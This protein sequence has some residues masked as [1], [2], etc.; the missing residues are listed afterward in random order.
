M[1]NNLLPEFRNY[2]LSNNIVPQKKIQ[3]YAY[4]ASNFMA[5]SKRNKGMNM[6]IT[7][8]SYLNHLRSNDQ[9]AD[10]QLKQAEEAVLLY[11]N[12]YSA[13]NSELV[14]KSVEC[15]E[16][17]NIS[18]VIYELRKAIRVKHYSYRTEQSYIAWTKKYYY[19]LD[20][21][22]PK[23]TDRKRMN[24]DNVRDYLSHLA[25]KKKVSASTQNQAFNALLFLSRNVFNFELGN[26]GKTVRAKRGRRLPSVLSI[27][28][29]QNVLKHI[30]GVNLLIVQMLYGAG[31]RLM[32]VARLR[33][34]DIDFS[35][36]LIFVRDSKGDND[37]STVLPDSIIPQL[38]KQ[39]IITKE[40]HK[41]DLNNGYGAVYMPNALDR[42]Y[43]NA[44]KQWH[45]QYVFPSTKLSV[46]RGSGKIR[47]HHI[48]EKTI[49]TSL[50]SAV[51]KAGI[52][53]HVFVHTL[54]HS[55]ATHLLMKG[56]NIR[57]I[58][59]L[60][61]HKHVE[62]TMIYTHVLRDIS[63]VPQSPLDSLVQGK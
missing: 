23:G 41:K 2:L 50:K 27:E 11:I 56:V 1:K 44:A 37:R 12:H 31:L 16:P 21:C 14:K 59:Q 13:N 20:N 58:Q 51:R 17:E 49:Q 43:P 7:I 53:K 8:Q 34:K 52:A 36:K 4:W 57:E 3:F 61:G 32:E 40:L 63:K 6:D 54:R 35:S 38:R 55:F 9:I 22:T 42:K 62:T 48:H 29:V 18:K 28:E 15:K 46:D 26:L 39:L 24:E 5:F 47:R 25:V 45:W 33:I 19:Y 30:D 10:W 60:L